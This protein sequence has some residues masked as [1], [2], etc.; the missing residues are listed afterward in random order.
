MHPS[1]GRQNPQTLSNEDRISLNADG[2]IFSRKPCLD[3]QDWQ[4][5]PRRF[6]LIALH[7]FPLKSHPKST[8]AVFSAI[9]SRSS[10]N[11]L[12][13]RYQGVS[14]IDS[15]KPTSRY[16]SGFDECVGDH[17]LID[18]AQEIV[19]PMNC[20]QGKPEGSCV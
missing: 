2:L 10:L 13:A 14:E 8:V 11:F 17:A 7:V 15:H 4:Q 3:P 16:K 1:P 6:S 12:F 20:G 19:T 9:A 18:D 5:Q